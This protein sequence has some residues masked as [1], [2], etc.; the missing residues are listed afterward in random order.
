MC[1]IRRRRAAHRLPTF[2][3]KSVSSL[4]ALFK[5]PFAKL[6]APSNYCPHLETYTDSP[7]IVKKTIKNLY[8]MS[9]NDKNGRENFVQCAQSAVKIAGYEAA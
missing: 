3:I 7:L 2:R 6:K 4:I 9:T 1:L 5:N 8:K